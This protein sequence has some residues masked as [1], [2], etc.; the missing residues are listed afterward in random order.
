MAAATR[1]MLLLFGVTIRVI[2]VLLCPWGRLPASATR[3]SFA[4]SE[5]TRLL[6]G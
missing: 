3:D 2:G 6:A 4:G 5:V 1:V